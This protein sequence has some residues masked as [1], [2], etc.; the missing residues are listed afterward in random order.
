MQQPFKRIRTDGFACYSVKFSPFYPTKSAVAGSAN[1]GLVGNG[2]LSVVQDTPQALTI[3]KAFDTQDGLYD[4]AWSE[5]HEN[6]I[7]TASGDGSVK[8]WD[9]M[10][11]DFPIRK[12]HEHQRE[13]FSIDWS[14]TQ[15]ELF[16]TSSWDG[17]I[18]IWTPDRTQSLT[19]IPAH[20]SCVY[21]AMFSPHQPSIIA[22]CSSDG[23]LKLFD[24]RSPLPLTTPGGG[25]A[26]LA[27]ANMTTQAHP[28]AEILTLDFNK[29]SPTPL[30]ATGSVD[31]TIRI[32][33][34]R[35][36]QPPPLP[37]SIPRFESNPTVATLLGHEYA[38]RK[39]AWSPH[40]RDRLLSSSYDMTCRQWSTL[41][42]G[43]GGGGGT[44]QFSSQGGFGGRLERVWD[45]HQEFVVGCA[46]SLFD[47][48][49]VASCSWDQEVHFWK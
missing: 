25:G 20:A 33:D 10:L 36:S 43:G 42:S 5:V 15:K 41:P 22:S 35:N 30:I 18:K 29:Y 44:S 8:L 6:Q 40:E 4:L 32:H 2:R 48:G 23:T 19:T 46:W 34:L 14:N 45:R 49:L 7:A 9:V 1:F 13:V 17:T 26:K 3:E 39:V 47:P 11:N 21:Q 12:W 31:R 16:C 38:V 27:Q 28:N 24:T 37:E